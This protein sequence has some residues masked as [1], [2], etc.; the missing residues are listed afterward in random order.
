MNILSLKLVSIS[1]ADSSIGDD[2][3]I[4]IETL[5][6]FFALNKKLQK[7]HTADIQ[8]EIAQIPVPTLPQTILV[9]MRIIERDPIF[10]DV[11][12]ADIVLTVEPRE[13]TSK[14]TSHRITVQEWRGVLGKKAVFTVAL[15]T[16][17][18][19]AIRYVLDGKNGWT[20]VK[21][22]DGQKPFSLSTHTKVM[23]SRRDNRR[24]YF[25]VMEGPERGRK[26][27]TEFQRS[28]FLGNKNEQRELVD[29]TYSIS[30]KTLRLGREVYQTVDYKNAPWAPGTYDVELPDFPHPGGRAYLKEAPHAL[31]WFLVGHTGERYIHIGSRS[32]GCITLIE[33]GRW[34]KLYQILIRARKGD[35][36]SVGILHVIA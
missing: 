36:V 5:G 11:E 6:T 9:S 25:T 30:K 23:L 26:A 17:I 14:Q 15:E 31:T 28:S 27:S 2:I 33:R 19:P 29:L 21:P 35:G 13:Q 24:E 34:E 7:G 32:A 16:A 10:N 8:K 12:N 20:G 18:V 1:Y 4:E 3:R 22:E